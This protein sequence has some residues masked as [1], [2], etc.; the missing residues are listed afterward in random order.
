VSG[1][2]CGQPVIFN[3]PAATQRLDVE[4]VLLCDVLADGTVAGVALVEPVYDQATGA[5]LATRVVDPVT[6]AEYVPQGV[7]QECPANSTCPD[8]QT[9]PL[10]DVTPGPNEWAMVPDNGGLSPTLANGITVTW[11]RNIAAGAVYPDPNMISWVPNGSTLTSTLSTSK[12]AQ[13]RIGV[14]LDANQQLTLPPGTQIRSLSAHHTYDPE[15]RVLTADGTSTIAGDESGT[16]DSD[17][18]LTHIYIPRVATSVQF[19]VARVGARVG[20]DNIEAAPADPYPFLRTIC[21]TCNGE[22]T[23]TDTETDGTTP[24]T[25]LGTAG[26]C[27]GP[28]AREKGCASPTTPVTSVGLCLADGTPIAV[29]VIRDCDGA[30]SSEGWL[31]LATGAWTAGT[32]PAGTVAC[33]DSTSIQV[34]GTFCDVNAA[35]EVVGLVLV[36]YTYDDTG[37]ISSVRLVDAVT[38][39]TYTPTGTVTVCPA[40]VAQPEQDAVILCHTAPDGTTTTFLRDYRRDENGA[41]T[42][43]SDYTLDGAPYVPPAGT[44]GVCQPRACQD[45]ETLLLCD[46]G[47]GAPAT[48]TGT[49]AS[50]T[51]PNGI[52]WTAKNAGPVGE[53]TAMP[54]KVTN[55]DGAWWGLHSFPNVADAPTRFTLSRPSIVEFSV[56]L[57]GSSTNPPSNQAQLPAGLDVVQMPDGY[58][59]DA[60]SGLLTRVPP[61]T[62]DP[63]SYVTDPQVENLPRFRTRDEVTTFVTQPGKGSRIAA[64]TTFFTYYA[65]AVTVIPSGQ[66]LR[67]ICRDCT[68]QVTGVTD[69][70]LDGVTPYTVRGTAGQCTQEPPCN[71]TVMGECVYSLPDRPF[72]FDPNSTAYPG[73]WLAT[74]TNPSWVFGDRVTAWEGTYQSDTGT[75]SAFGAIDWTAFTPAIPLHPT[76]SATNYVGTATIG[77]VTV[78]LRSLAGNGI[79][80]NADN[81]KLQVDQGDRFRIEFS[82]PIRLTLT[83]VGFGDP[84]TPSNERFCGVVTETVPWR[85]VK[86]AD[87]QGRITVVDADTRASL[88]ANAVLTCGNDGCCQPVQVCIQQIP[89]QTRE[90]ISNEQHRNDNSVDPVWKWTPD[91]NAASPVWYDMYQYQFSAD[92]T[93][94]DSDTARPAW[95]VSPHPDGRSAQ[96]SPPRPNEGPSLLNTHWYPRAFFDL[97]DN[98]DPAT[99]KVQAT[100]FNADQAGR[101]FRLNDGAWQTLPATATHNGVTYTFGPDAIPGAKAG[102]NALYLDVE[103]TVG[104]GAGLMVHLKVFYQVIPETRSWTRMVCCDNS[105]YYLDEDGQRQDSVPDGWRVAPCFLPPSSANFG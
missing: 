104:G 49:A 97:P 54:P 68:G 53:G 10:C 101:A 81:T 5:R 73:C 27:T 91:L 25:V 51:L 40:G 58:S 65:G 50:G 38:G 70:E 35:G 26:A 82:K 6:G 14:S 47:A 96:S 74:A 16:G 41:I 8:C 92:W 39:D 55:G 63:C 103:E 21:R 72:G 46:S 71:Q 2:G 61:A 20:F 105:I 67:R 62:A 100:V 7:L 89:V 98:A 11:T 84:P 1:C 45:C 86:L 9:I 80:R 17:G 36:E 23:V 4:T 34:S 77:G 56:Y 13:V 37:A 43:H 48:I 32:V 42:G 28:T 93:V 88:P 99:I 57:I 79:A 69:T 94:T 29:T 22:T 64:C 19:T 75:V 85:A 78:T 87:C 83:T 52:S 90:F 31:N 15:T 59:Y 102:R 24:Y 30:V 12:V 33:G 95:W 76:Q 60:A 3:N 44:I 18:F 66:F